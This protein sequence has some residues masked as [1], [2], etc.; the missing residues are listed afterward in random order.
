MKDF[1]ELEVWKIARRF[2]NEMFELS[3]LL[4]LGGFSFVYYTPL[5][6]LKRGKEIYNYAESPSKEI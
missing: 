2:R 5:P 4:W 6:P 3:N 1:T